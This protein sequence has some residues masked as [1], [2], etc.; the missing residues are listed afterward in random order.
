M[1]PLRVSR[2]RGSRESYGCMTSQLACLH[3]CHLSSAPNNWLAMEVTLAIFN[4]KW[5]NVSRI[6][7]SHLKTQSAP[8]DKAKYVWLNP[9]NKPA[10]PPWFIRDFYD[11]QLHFLISIFPFKWNYV[12]RRFMDGTED[13]DAKWRK[14]DSERER[15][16]VFSHLKNLDLMYTY[17][18]IYIIF[19]T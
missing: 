3:P 18:Y 14:P 7:S 15:S 5:K 4:S 11:L 16:H 6:V 1:Q 10:L 2:C 19:L 9:Q 12:V 8:S 13:H 17:I